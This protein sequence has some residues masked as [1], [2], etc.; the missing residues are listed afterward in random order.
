MQRLL[1]RVAWGH[2][3]TRVLIGVGLLVRPAL[4]RRWFGS[5]VDGGGGRVALQAFAVREAA[6]GA[7]QLRSLSTGRPVRL[8]FRLGVAFEVVDAVA[9]MRQRRS[10]PD[11]P[12]PDAV[13]LFAASG[14][15]GGAAVGWLL[16]E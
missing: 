10:L 8:W 9:T 15:I 7:G 3:L 14:V 5:A 11:G 6:V 16:R 13:A 2:A 1:R 12:V 4:G